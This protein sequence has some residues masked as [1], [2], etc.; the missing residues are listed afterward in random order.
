MAFIVRP[1]GAIALLRLLFLLLR[2]VSVWMGLLGAPVSGDQRMM[3]AWFGIRGIGSIYYL[4]YAIHH[5]LPAA[6]ADQIMG[7]TLAAVA[8]SIVLHGISV[9]PMMNL[10][11]RRKLRREAIR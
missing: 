7:I 6:M 10:Y 2:P 9:R 8:T 11:W 4:M 5:G 1:V 3:I